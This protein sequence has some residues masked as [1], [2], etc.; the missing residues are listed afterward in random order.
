VKA[1]GLNGAELK[2]NPQYYLNSGYQVYLDG[3]LLGYTGNTSFPLYRLDP[4]KTYKAEVR[5]V[6]GD[7]TIGPRHNKAELTFSI[8]S[9]LADEVPLTRLEPVRNTNEFPWGPGS[10]SRLG[11]RNY[12]EMIVVPGGTEI[13]YDLQGLYRTFTALIGV[14][15][16]PKE[17]GAVIFKITVDGKEL[18]QSGAMTKSD[19]PQT[20]R[21]AIDGVKRLVLRVVITGAKK[22]DSEQEWPVGPWG[23]WAMPHLVDLQSP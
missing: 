5:S 17:N 15:D 13:E 4:R 19:T 14:N 18:W 10:P 11:G 1:A 9:V 7:A 20:V 16:G 3:K 2:W 12:D 21:V 6:W 8:L 23:V 22:P